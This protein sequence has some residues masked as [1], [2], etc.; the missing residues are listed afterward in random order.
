M[1][2]THSF[3]H[4]YSYSYSYTDSHANSDTNSDTYTY[5]YSYTNTN[6]DSDSDTYSHSYTYSYTYSDSDT[7]TDTYSYTYSDSRMSTCLG[8]HGRGMPA[9]WQHNHSQ[10][11]RVRSMRGGNAFN[12]STLLM[13][14]DSNTYAYSNTNSDRLPAARS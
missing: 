14:T 1:W 11:E 2:D 13:F 8:A 7:N 10:V 12:G 3:T 6:T 5:S 9:M 4:S